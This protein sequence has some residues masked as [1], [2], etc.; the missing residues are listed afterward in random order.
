[1]KKLFTLSAILVLY[2]GIAIA[3]PLI[4]SWLLNTNG[5]RASQYFNNG[6]MPP[7]YNFVNMTDSADA[8]RVCYTASD[9]Y[10]HCQGLTVNMGKWLNPGGAVAQNYTFRFP[11]NPVQATTKVISSK[12][13]SIGLLT[14]GV[15]IFGLSN[16]NSWSGTANA[17]P[18]AG[19]RGIWN[20]EVGL[21]EGF[22]LDTAL[23][24]HPQQQGAY[25]SHTTPFRLYKRVAT[26]LHSPLVGY[27]Y[28]GFPVYGPYGY[29]D[30]NDATSAVT[31]MRTGYSL[32]NITT[33]TTMPG[34]AAATQNGPPVNGTY[35]IGTYCE[36]YEWLASNG[37]TLDEYNG[38]FC[39]TPEY[40]EGT[41]AYFV[42]M[43]AAGK[44]AF[45]YYI[46][47]Y[48]YGQPD[49]G[50]FSNGPQGNGLTI[51]AGAT[52]RTDLPTSVSNTVAGG[53]LLSVFPN[54]SAGNFTLAGNGH[55]YNKVIVF[56]SLGKPVYT[57]TVA[58]NE[59]HEITLHSAGIYLLR[60][61]DTFSGKT[62]LKTVVVK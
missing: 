10:V 25:H 9:V 16:A 35:P 44:A 5:R 27:A 62:A 13:G 59:N 61:E 8:V 49:A 20:V 12:L 4:N 57:S 18:Q 58:G 31:R 47:I 56:N 30:P 7:T 29:T 15:P 17:N 2:S 14:N 60:C 42:T 40:P 21:S 24:A 53:D 26:N 22:V 6:G 54:P 32:R 34:G 48:Y 33:R 46:G 19:G 50:N 1:M 43:D 23:G 41:Y 11:R 52:C 36:D 55:G 37:G 38:R 3:Q 39:I 28:D 45:P 51:P